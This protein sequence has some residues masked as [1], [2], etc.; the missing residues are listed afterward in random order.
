MT[1]YL[2]TNLRGR[3]KYYEDPDIDTLNMFISEPAN[4]EDDMAEMLG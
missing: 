1:C 2:L 3:H 4:T